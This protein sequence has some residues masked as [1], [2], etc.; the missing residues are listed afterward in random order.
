MNPPTYK[1][2]M[3]SNWFR[4][5]K[6]YDAVDCRTRLNGPVTIQIQTVNKC[7]GS[8]IMCPYS[9]TASSQSSHYMDMDLFIRIIQEIK[10]I[11]TVRLLTMMLQNEP[12]LD[13]I[14]EQRIRISREIMGDKVRIATV[15]NGSLLNKERTEKLLD[16]GLNQLAVSIDAFTGETF[17]NIRRGL[18]F[19][20]V[21]ENTCY[22]LSMAPK[23][24]VS[25]I[26]KFLRQDI[27]LEEEMKFISFWSSKGAM[28]GVDTLTN[29]AGMIKDYDAIKRRKQNLHQRILHPVFNHFIPCCP[30]PFTS[31][32]ILADGRSIICCHDWEHNEIIGDVAT[33]SLVEIWNGEK[34]N[35]HRKLLWEKRGDESCICNGC[36]LSRKFW[37]N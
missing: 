16:C 27:N 9:V 3:L 24:E 28:V 29:R 19:E 10:E 23:S 22:L 8:C 32:G 2:K 35:H 33:Q 6:S 4:G 14:L 5:Y 36:S 20:R 13:P 12:L 15:T 31:M 7:N 11:G 21:V 17:K 34:I 18:N 1:L 26:V 37:G 30:L 25:V